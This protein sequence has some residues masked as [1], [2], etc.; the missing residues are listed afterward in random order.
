MLLFHGVS[1][2]GFSALDTVDYYTRLGARERR[3]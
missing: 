3:R 1:D 2:P